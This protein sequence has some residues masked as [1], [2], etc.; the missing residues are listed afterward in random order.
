MKIFVINLARRPD[1]LE[2]VNARLGRLGL[3]AT[4]VLAIDAEDLGALPEGTLVSP[5]NHACWASHLVAHQDF[6]SSGESHALILED[7]AVLDASLDWIALVSELPREMQRH[8][9]DYLQ[10]GHL[11]TTYRFK[12]VRKLVHR[13]LGEGNSEFNLMLGTRKFIALDGVSRAGTHG[14][15]VTR[16]MAQIL[17]FYNQPSW[18]SPDGFLERLASSRRNAHVLRMA[19]LERSL[20]GQESRTSYRSYIDS[21]VA[22]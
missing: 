2:N 12:T 16:E 13:M 4:T 20:V 19:C 9:L 14:Y 7:D 17:G 10:V 8:S 6:L 18:S 22:R 21:D 1:R 15:V 11:P 5:S 3:A